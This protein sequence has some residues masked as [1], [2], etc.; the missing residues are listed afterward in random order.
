MIGIYKKNMNPDEAVRALFAEL[1]DSGAIDFALLPARKAGMNQIF[2]AL[3][4]EKDSLNEVYPLAPVMPLSTAVQLSKITRFASPQKKLAVLLKPCESRAAV[5]LVK[6]R[7]INL[8]NVLLVTRDCPGTVK[9]DTFESKIKSTD[10]PVFGDFEE[11]E[12]RPNCLMCE[13]PVAP[14]SDINIGTIGV[15]GVIL[16]ACSEKGEE[17]LKGIKFESELSDR[18][19]RDN[20]VTSLKEKRTA[21]AEKALADLRKDVSGIDS[22]LKT[23]AKCVNC[24]NCRTMCPVCYCNECFFDSA[25]FHF[26]GQRYEEWTARKGLLQMPRDEMLFHIGRMNHIGLSCVACGMC[27]QACPHDIP[28]GQVFTLISRTAQKELDIHAG[29]SLSDPL[30]SAT[31][32]E[33]EFCDMGEEKA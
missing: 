16:E 1:F 20:A 19:A 30:P 18:S 25:T 17:A 33:E 28:V 26:E 8:D 12:L 7:Q 3:V 21:Y 15:E 32:R 4:G 31:Y 22:L 6:L 2:P 13:Y 29:L 24:H 5:E 11:E 23:F 27:E 9:P 14:V 10:L